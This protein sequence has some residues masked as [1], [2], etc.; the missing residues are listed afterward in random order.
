MLVKRDG[1]EAEASP[2]CRGEHHEEAEAQEGQVGRRLINHRP[3]AQTDSHEDEGPEGDKRRWQE[4][5]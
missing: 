3:V 2:L 1:R 4:P 5:S